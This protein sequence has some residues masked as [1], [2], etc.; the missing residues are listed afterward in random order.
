MDLATFIVTSIVAISGTIL[1]WVKYFKTKPINKTDIFKAVDGNHKIDLILADITKNVNNVVK[2]GIIETT[3]GGGIPQA[4][5]VT[6]K[7]VIASTDPRVFTQF[8]EKTP[9]DSAYNKIILDTL[10]NGETTWYRENM[11]DP[12]VLALL[13]STEVTNGLVFMLRIEDGIRLLALA[14]DFKEHY[15]TTPAEM[16]Y[17]RDAKEHIKKILRKS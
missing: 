2:A 10:V 15:N 7:R 11:K 5:R 12:L 16:Y 4:G 14:V 3:N 8:G 9:N 6:Y 13:E 17:L 1:A